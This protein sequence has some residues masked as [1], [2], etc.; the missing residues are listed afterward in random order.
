MTFGPYLLRCVAIIIF[1]GIGIGYYR[2]V[3]GWSVTNCIYFTTASVTTVG[4]GFFHPT[5][6]NSR[7]FTVFFDIIGIFLVLES[8]NKISL[9]VFCVVQDKIL[10]TFLPSSTIH[11]RNM[12]KVALNIFS[13]AF[14]VLIGTIFFAA[15]EPWSVAE[16][17]YWVMMTMTTVGYGDLYVHHE[18]SRQFSIFFIFWV[19]SIY[20]VA[21]HNIFDSWK[22]SSND[23]KMNKI[24]DTTFNGIE[25]SSQPAIN[26]NKFILDA[27]LKMKV[28]DQ[29]RDIDPILQV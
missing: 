13:V 24:I 11:G 7:I 25:L 8:V 14:A 17:F 15:N 29:A 21:L 20:F 19:V 27:L 16:A 18:T 26:R 10:D 4:Y 12:K 2:S 6:D 9:E 3:E 1:Y 23:A 28:V 22:A 5:T